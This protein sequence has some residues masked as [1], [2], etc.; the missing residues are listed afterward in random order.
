M[1]WSIMLLL[2]ITLEQGGSFMCKRYD[3]YGNEWHELAAFVPLNIWG[4][5]GLAAQERFKRQGE[6]LEPRH[7]NRLS[8]IEEQMVPISSF[9]GKDRYCE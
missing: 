7:S 9:L 1:M 2:S 6:P 8:K 4:S 5:D 3:E